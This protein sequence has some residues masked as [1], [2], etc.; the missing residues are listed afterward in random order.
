MPLYNTGEPETLRL[1]LTALFALMPV[2]IAAPGSAVTAPPLQGGVAQQAPATLTRQAVLQFIREL[3]AAEKANQFDRLPSFFLPEAVIELSLQIGQG[4]PAQTVQLGVAQFV[5]LSRQGEG[6]I[7][8]S[9]YQLSI[10]NIS[11]NGNQATI[12]ATVT[13][14][15]TLIDGQTVA[16]VTQ[17]TMQLVN[18]ATGPKISRL[19]GAAM[20]GVSGGAPGGN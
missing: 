2:A 6:Q 20:M 13:E 14:Q 19:H 1:L 8:R 10:N 5:A 9:S 7:A 12:H 3:E 4:Q 17:E 16:T 11:I 18:T 15:S